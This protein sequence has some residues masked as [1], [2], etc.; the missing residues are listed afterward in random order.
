MNQVNTSLN[1]LDTD[2][3]R[4]NMRAVIDNV[5]QAL[6]Q[7]ADATGEEAGV[8]RSRAGRRLHDVQ[9]RIG[10]MEHHAVARIRRAGR[11]TQAYVQDHPW[12]LVGGLTIAAAAALA[13]LARTRH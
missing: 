11:R 5:E 10:D 7:L 12:Q 6:H 2:R 8:L 13:L 4:N 3:L 9:D 1:Q